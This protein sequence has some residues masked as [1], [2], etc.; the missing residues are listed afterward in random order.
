MTPTLITAGT[1]VAVTLVGILGLRPYAYRVRIAFDVICFAA[2]S[3]FL[4]KW[5]ITPVFPPVDGPVDGTVLS[6]RVIGGMWWLLG[7]RIVVAVLWVTL[8]R[9]RRSRAARLFSDLTAA[10]VYVAAAL[11]VLNSVL[12]L[13][14]AG[15]L[16]TSGVVAIVLGLAL[17]NTLADVFAGIAVG[18]EGPFHVGDRI[19]IG[20]KIEGE[21]IQVNWRSIRVQT[22]GEDV[23]IIPNSLVAKAEIVNRSYPSQR[24][25]VSVELSCPESAAPEQVIDALLQATL[26][27]P[28]IL[29]TPAPVAVI[30]RLDEK[31]NSYTV[32]FFVKDS[33]Q[34]SA[35]KSLLLRQCRRQL[36]YAELLS[37]ECDDN[38][39]SPPRQASAMAYP[40]RRLLRELILFESLSGEQ[41]D[42]LAAHLH[43]RMLEPGEVLFAQGSADAT[44]YIVASGILE[45]TRQTA[46]LA[47]ESIG[48][49]GA[50]EYV[51]EIGLLTGVPHAVTAT[52]HA[53]SVVYR[54]SRDAFAPLLSS[55]SELASALDKSVRHGLEILHREVS[56]RASA[57][58]G[59]KG[60]L[61][62]RIRSFFQPDSQH[63][64]T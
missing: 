40:G 64:R 10:V 53:H 58:I 35:G 27:C 33:Q 1:I 42:Q 30:T 11:V 19:S 25:K 16:A 62:S 14:I 26:L 2:I 44:L 20:D 46:A 43:R 36:H 4:L 6:L 23:A 28:V 24:R 39:E 41:I 56:I 49:I 61:L 7:A 17:Q 12:T 38:L 54:L 59:A 13:P 5:G 50:G 52:A 29:Q 45:F 9:D 55:E 32:S 8:H 48:C 34:V 37:R 51:G 63:D 3:T 18:I 31:R 21:V 60:Q 22:D 57:N 47:A 15:L